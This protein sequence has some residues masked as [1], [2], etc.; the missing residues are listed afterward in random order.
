MCE[1]SFSHS[2]FLSDQII[3]SG[4]SFFFF[5]RSGQSGSVG[6]SLKCQHNAEDSAIAAFSAA[7]RLKTGWDWSKSREYKPVA[8]RF[9]WLSGNDG[10]CAKTRRT[11]PKWQYYVDDGVDAKRTGWYDFSEEGSQGVEEVYQEHKNNLHVKQR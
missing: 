3:R 5:H 7:F 11:S 1:T 6:R 2:P 9:E 4:A 8:G 10:G